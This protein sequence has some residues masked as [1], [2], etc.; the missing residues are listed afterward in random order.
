[1]AKPNQAENI[2]QATQVSDIIQ[3]SAL[4]IAITSRRSLDQLEK[5]LSQLDPNSEE[6]AKLKGPPSP[7]TQITTVVQHQT[8]SPPIEE[9]YKIPPKRLPCRDHTQ[10]PKIQ[11]P[12]TSSQYTPSSNMDTEN[13]E[14]IPEQKK[15]IPPFFINPNDSWPDTCK[16]LTSSVESLNI[17]LSKGHFLKL[18]VNSERDYETLKSTLINQNILFKCHSLKKKPPF[19]KKVKSTPTQTSLEIKMIKLISQPLLKANSHRTN[20]SRPIFYDSKISSPG[21]NKRT[22]P[23]DSLQSSTTGHQK[24]QLYGRKI[25]HLSG[26]IGQLS[27]WSYSQILIIAKLKL[28]GNARK[29]YEVSLQN[30]KELTYEKFKEAMTSHCKETPPFATEFAKFS[31]VVQFEFEN[32]KDFSIRAQGLSQKCLESDSENEKVSKRNFFF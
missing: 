4:E 14:A 9:S 27:G 16:L 21:R 15:H 19:L 17:S 3:K 22:L 26:E 5:R 11:E 2:I 6:A 29:V 24:N 7:S 10:D 12:E 32:I 1:E 8:E 20:G 23:I 30:D 18:T 13:S 25:L 28:E 31:S